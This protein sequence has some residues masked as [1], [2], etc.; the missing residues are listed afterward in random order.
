MA[1]R[2][3]NNAREDDLIEA[4]LT[5]IASEGISRT[6]VRR[7]AEYAGVSNGLIRF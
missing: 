3:D 6:T 4:T 7:V 5:C 2:R 1:S